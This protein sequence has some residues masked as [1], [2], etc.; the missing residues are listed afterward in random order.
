MEQAQALLEP[1]SEV[2]VF[3]SDN[4]CFKPV[5][6]LSRAIVNSVNWFAYL[7]GLDIGLLCMKDMFFKCSLQNKRHCEL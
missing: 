6:W 7:T 1:C 2:Q 5:L 4:A 3:H